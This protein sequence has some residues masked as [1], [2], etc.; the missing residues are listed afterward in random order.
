MNLSMRVLIAVVTAAG[1]VGLAGAYLGAAALQD[2]SPSETVVQSTRAPYPDEP[3]NSPAALNDPGA[4]PP[5][6]DDTPSASA[7][8]PAGTPVPV[9]GG[10]K[11]YTD[12][13]LGFTFA[14]P[15]GLERT[16]SVFQLSEHGKIPATQQRQINF[17]RD[18]GQ[19]VVAVS[20]IPNPAGAALEDWIRTVPG[21]PCEPGAWPTCDPERVTIAG[22]EGIRFSINVLGNAAAT[23]FFAHGGTIYIL[24]G[25]VFG[26]PEYGAALDEVEFQTIVDGFRFGS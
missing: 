21:W 20:T 5:P 3:L 19:P 17:N 23:V 22:E 26:A 10:W 1:V 7:T 4:E 12:P 6:G 9:P 14:A 15:D 2:E 8:A 25:N 18:D 16:E 13:E 24:S 11:A